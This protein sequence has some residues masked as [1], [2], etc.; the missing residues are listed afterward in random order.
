[1]DAREQDKSEE[2]SRTDAR[3]SSA[4]LPLSSRDEDADSM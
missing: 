4:P 3:D 1:M 2:Q